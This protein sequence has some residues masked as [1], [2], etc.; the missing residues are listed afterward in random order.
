MTNALCTSTLLLPRPGIDLAKWSVIACD[1]YTA[2]PEY[3]R[4]VE[5]IVGDAPSSLRVTL[6]EAWLDESATR[7]PA[8]RATMD[9]YLRNGVWQTAVRDGFI[10]TER[11][12][13]SGV[14]PGLMACLDLDRY[15]F[16]PGA[17]TL[18]RPTEGT[19]ISR[20]P[21]RARIR[22]GAAVE[23]PGPALAVRL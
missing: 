9:A 20:V 13:S 12:T 7:I 21:P 5:A 4:E 11:T 23:L 3:W 18:I 1:Q 6:P 17:R 8:I 16:N 19:V 10:L 2:Q 22:A 14:R 15:D